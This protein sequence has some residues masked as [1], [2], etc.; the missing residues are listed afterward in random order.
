M[1]GAPLMPAKAEINTGRQI[2]FDY[3][4]GFFTPMILLIHAFQ[5]LVGA[6]EHV[7]AYK[8]VYILATM[9]GSAIFMFV[10][11]L[12][13]TYSR[14]TNAQLV[15]DGA[16]LLLWQLLWNV[17]AM[18]APLVIAQALRGLFGFE[19]AWASTWEL[20]PVMLQYINVFFI[21]GVCYFLLALLRY[22]KT[23]DWAYFALALAFIFVNPCI[24]MYDKR[25]GIAA[26][27]YV[28]TMFVGDRAAISLCCVSHFPYA[29]LGVGFGKVL[30]RTENKTRLYKIVALPS[31][32]LVIAHFVRSFIITDGLDAL[33][34]YSSNG[35][36]YPDAL[37][38]LANCGSV[39]LM[40][41]ALHV[42]GG[43]IAK[44]KPLH[45]A[46]IHFSKMTT[47][48]YAVHPFFYQ[49]I[50]A[51][52][53]FAPFSALSCVGMTFVVWALCFTS[54]RV[55]SRIRFS[56]SR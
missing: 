42:L 16:K 17:L 35:Y 38:A 10:L 8:I 4:K 28:L 31:A 13:S 54:L 41:A 2:E 56:K 20:M 51:F 5:I 15:K 23:P 21:A 33:F 25:T 30:R 18:A 47:P 39:L 32:L 26:L 24:Y 46:L 9:T 36:V 34:I 37:R 45:N 12:G 7:G 55:W 1:K 50:S 19:T 48:Y 14:R 40:A 44:A 6:G 29:L 43:R 52:A 22:I 53:L 3:M 11:G 49:L 27:D